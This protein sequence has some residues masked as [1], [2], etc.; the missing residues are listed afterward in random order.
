MLHEII[1]WYLVDTALGL[2]PIDW[3][4]RSVPS[5][6]YHHSQCSGTIDRMKSEVT[7]QYWALARDSHP[8]PSNPRPPSVSFEA[9]SGPYENP[10]Y[11]TVDF[12]FIFKNKSTSDIPSPCD[13]SWTTLPGAID[14]SVPTLL[15]KWDKA[16]STHIMLTHFDENLFNVSTLESRVRI[17]QLLFLCIIPYP[18]LQ[19]TINTVLDSRGT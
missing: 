7:R 9:L 12:C 18:I 15:A 5:S 11:G 6:S 2:P 16:W 13:D 17:C 4:T 3:N 8:R 10:G 14:P 19:H 1:K